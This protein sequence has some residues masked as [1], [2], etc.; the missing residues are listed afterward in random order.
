MK[1]IV[2]GHE[3]ETRDIVDI[4][5]AGR[6]MHGFIIYLTEN[7]QLHI[8]EKQQYDMTPYECCHIN[9]RYRELREKVYKK[10]Q[11]DKSDI[12]VFKL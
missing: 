7:R 6:R 5:E 12:P 3:I 1:I 10:W 9:N 11:E 8:T 2:E 4:V